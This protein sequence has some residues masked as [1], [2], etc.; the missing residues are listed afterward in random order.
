M[1]FKTIILSLSSLQ[2]IDNKNMYI[3]THAH[4]FGYTDAFINIHIILQTSLDLIR[5]GDYAVF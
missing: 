5:V 3:Y 2:C 4:T 1:L